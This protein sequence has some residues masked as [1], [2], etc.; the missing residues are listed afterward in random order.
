LPVKSPPG[1]HIPGDGK[2]CFH[3]SAEDTASTLARMI[4]RMPPILEALH[5]ALVGFAIILLP[6]S[7]N[8]LD[9]SI[10]FRGRRVR[11]TD[12]GHIHIA[13]RQLRKSQE[14]GSDQLVCE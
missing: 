14:P 13:L 10:T 1:S 12:V 2:F 5:Q 8:L 11:S 4:P 6:P 3:S 7:D 9:L